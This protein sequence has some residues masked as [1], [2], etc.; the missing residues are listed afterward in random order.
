[1]KNLETVYGAAQRLLEE[2]RLSATEIAD[3]TGVS[4]LEIIFM[5]CQLPLIGG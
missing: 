4:V 5:R 1:M 2:G 3:K